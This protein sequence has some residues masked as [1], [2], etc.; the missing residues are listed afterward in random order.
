MKIKK[1][2]LSK[3]RNEEHYKFM[4]DF[5]KSVT[6]LSPATLGIETQFQTFLPLY[7]DEIVSLDIIRKSAATEDLDVTDCIRNATYRGLYDAVK[8]ASNHFKPEVKQAA[9]HLQK[10]FKPYGDITLKTFDE[11][12]IAINSLVADLK[13]SYA[14]DA[15]IA[16]ITDWVMELKKNNDSFDTLKRK[17]FPEVENKNQIRMKEVRTAIDNVYYTIVDRI[18][19]LMIV[20]GTSSYIGFANE[21]NMR[22]ENYLIICSQ[23]KDRNPEIIDEVVADII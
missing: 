5:K 14:S 8:A 2:E 9:Y 22:I 3:L 13:G 7:V 10:A 15:A 23:C 11:E 20:N 18:N 16:G 12:T 6:N 4:T 19:A 21:I 1:I 17:R